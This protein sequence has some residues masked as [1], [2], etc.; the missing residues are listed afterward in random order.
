[1]PKEVVFMRHGHKDGVPGPTD[2]RKNNWQKT[3]TEHGFE[4]ARSIQHFLTKYKEEHSGDKIVLYASP[5][6]RAIMTVACFAYSTRT[7]T[8][9]TDVNSNIKIRLDRSL[10]ENSFPF[11]YK[12]WD[13][14]VWD[15]LIEK[16]KRNFPKTE[17]GSCANPGN[18]CTFSNKLCGG[19]FDARGTRGP[20]CDSEI[21][22]VVNRCHPKFKEKE[23][24][25]DIIDP[26]YKQITVASNSWYGKKRFLDQRPT[27][28]CEI[29]V[30]EYN[31]PP[32]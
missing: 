17:D 7:T 20:N 27:C 12:E 4:D 15:P 9:S 10:G 18:V 13:H 32:G 1:M 30:R 16:K 2:G 29:R 21:R 28:A 14:G 6:R 5:F 31:Q 22:R 25:L 11:A 23:D 3:L 26:E 24:V 19:I 8:P